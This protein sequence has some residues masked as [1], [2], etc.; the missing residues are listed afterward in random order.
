MNN[1]KFKQVLKCSFLYGFIR[2]VKQTYNGQMER[3]DKVTN[4]FFIRP[5]LVSEKIA[6]CLFSGAVS[7]GYLWYTIPYDIYELELRL[8]GQLHKEGILVDAFNN[9]FFDPI[10]TACKSTPPKD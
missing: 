2:G 9:A 5:M 4:T 6:A 10:F 3:R 1:A 8:T 7:I